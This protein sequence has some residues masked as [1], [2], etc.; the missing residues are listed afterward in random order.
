MENIL[1]IFFFLQLSKRETRVSLCLRCE[2]HIL[3]AHLPLL[4]MQDAS[5][6]RVSPFCF[7]R[8]RT[9]TRFSSVHR[10]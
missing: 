2:T 6:E 4:K 3:R 7:H 5:T 8:G 1:L 9:N 10:K